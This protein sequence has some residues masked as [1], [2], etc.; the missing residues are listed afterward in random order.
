MKS[1]KGEESMKWGLREHNQV[2]L[3]IKI[4]QWDFKSDGFLPM[5]LQGITLRSLGK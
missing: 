1:Q 3:G 5:A 4:A 2:N